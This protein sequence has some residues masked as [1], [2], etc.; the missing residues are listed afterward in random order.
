MND[1]FTQDS[2]PLEPLEKQLLEDPALMEALALQD[3]TNQQE[4][5][6]SIRGPIW[7]SVAASF[8]FVGLIWMVIGNEQS[9]RADKQDV[10]QLSSQD[11]GKEIVLPDG[12]QIS[13][14]THSQLHYLP[15]DEK[16]IVTF[17]NGEAYFDVAKDEARPFIIASRN[18]TITVLG[19]A[20][21]LDVSGDNTQLH[22]FHGKVQ[23]DNQHTGEQNT[24][25]KG[26]GLFVDN[27]GNAKL[28]SFTH[29]K[30]LWK[31]GW[32]AFSDMP[33]Q[34][35]ISKLNRYADK[36]LILG[37]GLA[38]LSIS[39]R[40]KTDAVKDAVNLIADMHQLKVS[41]FDD[42]LILQT[43]TLQN[44]VFSQPSQQKDL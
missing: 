8:F 6:K 18:T 33:L 3:Q 4:K 40:F 14:N 36:R 35:V 38:N 25:T 26:Q 24:L 39:G 21:N 9:V 28:L 29:Q 37:P 27:E 22:V 16:R 41:E 19:T 32:L 34:H 11:A 12:S 42:S 1:R 44:N 13:L 23:V 7:F 2:R 10:V 30:P 5:S 43:Q 31:K 20:F 17:D 15:S